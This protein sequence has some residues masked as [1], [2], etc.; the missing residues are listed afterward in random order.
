[1]QVLKSPLFL[2]CGVLFIIHQLLQK[3]L[4]I[5]IGVLDKYF[6]SLLAMPIILTLLLAERRWLFKKGDRYQLP[7][8]HILLTTLYIVVVTE[9]IFPLLSTRF[10][11]DVI[12]VLLYGIGS[13]I[14]YLVVNKKSTKA[15]T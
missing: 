9:I 12:D 7:V 4:L 1:M 6:D 5:K 13:F 2:F 3:V 10:T 11:G 8:A 14:F 15:I